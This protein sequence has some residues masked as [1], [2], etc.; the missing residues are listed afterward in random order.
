MLVADGMLLGNRADTRVFTFMRIEK[1]V[2]E[3]RIWNWE[4]SAYKSF[5]ELQD[6]DF[7]STV[8]SFAETKERVKP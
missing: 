6:L 3:S 1:C 8:Y 2:V 5:F 4:A 7:D